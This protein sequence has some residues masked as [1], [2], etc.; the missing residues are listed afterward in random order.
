LSRASVLSSDGSASRARGEVGVVVMG[1]V[2]R[3]EGAG[4]VGGDCTLE[5]VGGTGT[6]GTGWG[7][8]V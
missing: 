4:M 2:G 5:D 1:V 8:T 7:C 3:V 6:S